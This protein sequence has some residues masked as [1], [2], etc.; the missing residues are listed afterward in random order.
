MRGA[1]EGSA[2]SRG[3]YFLAPG[4]RAVSQLLSFLSYGSSMGSSKTITLPET[5]SS[6]LKMM[7][8]NR[9]LQTS[10]GIFSGA[11]LVSGR[12]TEN[13]EILERLF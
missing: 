7:V 8:S 12:V 5:N 6:H 13:V 11:M 9:N 10:R 1:L 4:K 2:E 3:V